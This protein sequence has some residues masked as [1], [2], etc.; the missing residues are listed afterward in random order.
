MSQKPTKEL[1]KKQQ[2]RQRI[3][4]AA[5]QSFRTYGYAGIGVDG[6]AK[7]AEVTSGAFY[8]HFGS[9]DGA[10]VAAIDAGLDEVIAGIPE[11]QQKDGNKWVESFIDYYLGK[12]HRKDLA[13]GCSM[14]T[15]SPEVV[16]VDPGYQL[17]YEKK[18]KQIVDI[19]ANG[20]EGG[21]LRER[22]ARTW[23]MLGTLIGGLTLSRAVKTEQI[24]DEIANSIKIAATAAAGK[25]KIIK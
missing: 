18:M 22:R 10:F 8:S 6:I 9:K 12:A 14:T 24:A 5:S 21:S 25:V 16:R 4:D 20:L 19:M 15:L 11:F 23:A 13:N 3:L 2:T 7:A 1:T 17:A